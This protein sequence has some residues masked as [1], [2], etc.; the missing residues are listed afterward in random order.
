MTTQTDKLG[1][2]GGIIRPSHQRSKR[3]MGRT[4]TTIQ[5]G[6]ATIVARM[7][8]GAEHDLCTVALNPEPGRV[9]RVQV[10]VK[11]AETPP[12]RL[13]AEGPLDA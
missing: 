12:D 1:G 4:L 10:L 2:V 11:T 5:A 13:Q 3:S 8:D 9:A 6:A 7:P